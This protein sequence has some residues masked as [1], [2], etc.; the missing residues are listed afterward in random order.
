MFVRVFPIPQRQRSAGYD[1]VADKCGYSKLDECTELL[2]MARF[3]AEC[4]TRSRRGEEFYIDAGEDKVSLLSARQTYQKSARL[5][6]GLSD[7]DA[8][9]E[10]FSRKVTGKEGIIGR[11]IPLG[12][13]ADMPF[14]FHDTIN[15]E[16]GC[17][18]GKYRFD[19]IWR[20]RFRVFHNSPPRC[21]IS[22][23]S[24]TLAI[25]IV[26]SIHRTVLA[27]TAPAPSST[28][29]VSGRCMALIRSTHNTG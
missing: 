19:G 26:L 22:L 6:Q 24:E 27:M 18:V 1:G 25:L 4:V 13:D 10:R 15:E 28:K 23:V 20:I 9:H 21:S 12:N 2:Y 5:G 7:E 8:R 29:T 11:K 16:K 14:Q 17:P 3:H